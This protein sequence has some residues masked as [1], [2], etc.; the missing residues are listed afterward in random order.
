MAVVKCIRTA[1]IDGH[2][3]EHPGY[4]MGPIKA[5]SKILKKVDMKINEFN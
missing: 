5:M 3:T 2:S 1:A 4:L